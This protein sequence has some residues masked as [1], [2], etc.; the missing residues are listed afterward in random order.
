[1]FGGR[2][3]GEDYDGID[4]SGLETVARQLAGGTGEKNE[5]LR[6]DSRCLSRDSNWED[7]QTKL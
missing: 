5:I 6:Q 2:K 4:G 3:I 1:M 7:F